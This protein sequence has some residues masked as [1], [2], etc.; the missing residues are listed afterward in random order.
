[1]QEQEEMRRRIDLERAAEAQRK[2][3]EEEFEM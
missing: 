1:V 3:R 2:K